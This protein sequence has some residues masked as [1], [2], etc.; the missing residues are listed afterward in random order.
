MGGHA[1]CPINPSLQYSITPLLLISYLL[2]FSQQL[3]AGEEA[4]VII[5]IE[6]AGHEIFTPEMTAQPVVEGVLENKLGVLAPIL[7][8]AEETGPRGGLIGP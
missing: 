5:G 7:P 1:P 3:P 2:E 6:V 4:I 8:G